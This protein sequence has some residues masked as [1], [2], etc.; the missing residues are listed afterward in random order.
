MK[1]A[2]S[3]LLALFLAVLLSGCNQLTQYTI[4]EQ[5]VNQAL[6]KRNNF[7]KDI[8][9]S[10]LVNA[11]IVLSDL[12]SQIGREEPGKITLSGKAN[13]NVSSL[14]G[15]QQA[16]MQLKM[17]AQ[18]IFNAQEGA[19]YLH[20]IEIVDAQVQPEKMASIMKTLTPYLNE[21]LKRYFN[22]KP[23]YVLSEDRSKGEALAKKFAKG[24]EVK[25]G[26]LVIPFTD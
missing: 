9:V 15:P 16:E 26:Q 8:G 6:Q 1:K 17:K 19:I 25:P 22:E 24:I 20:D 12:N 10:G 2:M 11:H 7:E 5:E 14:F 3:G 4:S 23:A 13:I 21:S 18:P